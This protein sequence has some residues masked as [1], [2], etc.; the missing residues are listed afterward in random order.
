MPFNESSVPQDSSDAL[1]V[2]I[3]N[4]VAVSASV[5]GMT[6]DVAI[7]GT[8]IGFKEVQSIRNVIIVNWVF[9]DFLCQL[10]EPLKYTLNLEIRE[11]VKSFFL[12]LYFQKVLQL[13]VLF[14]ITLISVEYLYKKLTKQILFK[15]SCLL[16]VA[17][18]GLMITGT[19][20]GQ[21]SYLQYII[22]TIFFSLSIWHFY[23]IMIY[24]RGTLKGEKPA[25]I[26]IRF[27]LV[28][29]F[30]SCWFISHAFS[31]VALFFKHHA[32]ILMAA[33]NL[34]QILGFLYP[35]L[36]L[37]LLIYCDLNFLVCFMYIVTC[38]WYPV[39]IR[40]T[41]LQNDYD[42][43]NDG[44]DISQNFEAKSAVLLPL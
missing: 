5:L 22:L 9:G 16:W 14:I 17:S 12:L 20:V 43:D 37:L 40:R 8:V 15:L 7:A 24:V 36:L 44:D 13:S 1:L 41:E 30:L 31:A 26:N 28:S 4:C 34:F 2:T 21:V 39:K 27:V 32:A 19:T 6:S 29:A 33:S 35:L 18:L 10:C 25:N 3:I 38:R 23:K 11:G 42:E